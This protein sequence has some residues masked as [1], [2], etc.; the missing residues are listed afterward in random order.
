[1][2]NNIVIVAS[3]DGLAQRRFNQSDEHGNAV[4]DKDGSVFEG[5]PTT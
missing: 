5:L 3:G 2:K 1:M 4:L